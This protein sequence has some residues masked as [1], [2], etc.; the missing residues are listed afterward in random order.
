[1]IGSRRA[2]ANV[3]LTISLVSSLAACLG[4]DDQVTI[5]NW[6]TKDVVIVTLDNDLGRYL[7]PACGRIVIRLLDRTQ[8]LDSAATPPPGAVVIREGLPGHAETFTNE[9]MLI[10]S[11]RL[12]KLGVVPPPPPCDGVPPTPPS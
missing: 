7:I 12:S 6:T 11:D 5:D 10:T 2:I 1:M 8:P 3:L 4:G 9:Y